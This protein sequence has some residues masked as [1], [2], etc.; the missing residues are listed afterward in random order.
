MF[1]Q[2]F[3]IAETFRLSK[4]EPVNAWVCAL[5]EKAGKIKTF[6]PYNNVILGNI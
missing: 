2:A 4:A 6:K 5:S 1:F 3:S